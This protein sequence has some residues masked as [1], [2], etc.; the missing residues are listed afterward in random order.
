MAKIIKLI[1]VSAEHKWL[2]LSWRNKPS[3][4]SLSKSGR[5]V[6][7]NEHDRWF[8][9]QMVS[10]MFS[11]V[12]DLDSKLIGHIRFDKSN[13]DVDV[14]IYLI[15][16][17]LGQ[18]VGSGALKLGLDKIIDTKFVAVNAVIRNDNIGSVNFFKKNGFV[19]FKEINV[20]LKI[21]RYVFNGDYD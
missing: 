9:G 8:D 5:P 10:D 2:L 3:I 16:E 7:A 6:N 12:I 17:A 1:P 13:I 21:Y 20:D 14:T 15:D 18:G 11:Y 19:F 4:I